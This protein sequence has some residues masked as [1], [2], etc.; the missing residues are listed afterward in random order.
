MFDDPGPPWDKDTPPAVKMQ[1]SKMG[2]I[3]LGAICLASIP[4][5][6]HFLTGITLLGSFAWAIHFL[7]YRW[8]V[9]RSGA[10]R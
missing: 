2:A 8:Q 6:N 4:F 5:Q 10:K 9:K 7:Y 1:R 3:I